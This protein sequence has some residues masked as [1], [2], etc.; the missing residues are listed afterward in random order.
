MS[1]PAAS[2]WLRRLL[3][4]APAWWVLPTPATIYLN[5]VRLT[6]PMPVPNL[7]PASWWRQQRHGLLSASEDRL[8]NIEGKGPGLATVSAVIV[9]AVVLALASGW[10]ESEP[11]GRVLLV[12]AAAYGG[13]SLMMPLYLVGPVKRDTLHVADMEQASRKKDPEEALA[14]DAAEAAMRN[15]LRNLGLVNLL[16]AAR[17]ELFY[18]F[19]ILLLWGLLVPATG[20]LRRDAPTNLKES[21]SPPAATTQPPH[22]ARLESAAA[23]AAAVTALSG[24][25]GKPWQRGSRKTITCDRLAADA[26][27]CRARWRYRKIKRSRLVTVSLLA[28]T[29]RTRVR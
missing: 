7:A 11:L 24:A 10:D 4:S 19:A 3:L 15:D 23:R 27:D 29:I 16:D 9:G 28:G 17:R 21:K 2:H 26:F 1:A 25:L 18:T 14:Q 22:G 6:A 8:R 20:L 12:L 13:V 5:R